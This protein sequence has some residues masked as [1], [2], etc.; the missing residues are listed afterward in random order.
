MEQLEALGE[1]LLD[2]ATMMDLEAWLSQ[3]QTKNQ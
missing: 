3:Q 2:L 1:A